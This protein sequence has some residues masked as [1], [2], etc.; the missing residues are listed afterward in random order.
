MIRH[1]RTT[2]R[3]GW[4]AVLGIAAIIVAATLPTASTMAVTE[5]DDMVLR[6]NTIAVAAIGNRR[7]D[8]GTPPGLGQV[9]P[10]A[11][12]HLAM[13]QGAV[14]DAVNAIDGGHEPYINGLSRAIVGASKAAAV[15]TAA[16]DVSS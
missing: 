6:W 10:L 4:R 12:I 1:S 9:P 7:R 3:R 15:V 2:R 8:G 16:Y 13:V 11:P 14:Y 5:P